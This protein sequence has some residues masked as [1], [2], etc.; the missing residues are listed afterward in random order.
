[1]AYSDFTLEEVTERFHLQITQTNLFASIPP[2]PATSWLLETLERS[3]PLAVVSE[4]ARSEFIVGP[5]LLALRDTCHD[6]SIYSG[7][8]LDGDVSVGLSGECDFIVAHGEQL[9]IFRAPVLTL[10]EAKKNDVESGLG[11]CAAQLLGA[12]LWNERHETQVE[13][14][15]GCV[16]TG[17]AWQFLSL[18]QSLL[19]IDATRYYINDLEQILGILVWISRIP[20]PIL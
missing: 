2:E 19:T 18:H 12:R 9:P 4:K 13:T 20:T 3:R 17:E 6:I 11:Q 10:I 14:L 5:I 16:T 1:M 7:Q 15:Y 8:R